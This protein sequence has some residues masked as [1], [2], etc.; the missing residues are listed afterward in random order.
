MFHSWYECLSQDAS[1]WTI[2]LVLGITLVCV[3]LFS[4]RNDALRRIS[5]IGR[6]KLLDGRWWYSK[7]DA[8]ELLDKLGARGR[9]LYAATAVTLDLFFPFAYGLLFGLLL[10]RLWP[11]GQAWLLLLPLVTVIA[12]LLENL[13]IAILALTYR[14]GGEAALAGP[15]AVFTLTKRIFLTLST[16]AVLIGLVRAFLRIGC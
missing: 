12:D 11:R 4:G 15:A 13:T 2:A 3:G 16:L 1:W 7:A 14:E 9:G 5:N 10:V 6:E 8:A